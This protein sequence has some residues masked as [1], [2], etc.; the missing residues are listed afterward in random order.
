MT[1]MRVH[2]PTHTDECGDVEY[3]IGSVYSDG[4]TDVSLCYFVTVSDNDTYAVQFRC[5]SR[6]TDDTD[7]IDELV[8]YDYA[9]ILSHDT[10]AEAIAV[11]D[12]HA[13]EDESWIFASL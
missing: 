4:D 8:S 13:M 3:E 2:G 10:L 6:R 7:G 9:S 12:S 1:W 5:A 11:A